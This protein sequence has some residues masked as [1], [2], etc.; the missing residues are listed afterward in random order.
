MYRDTAYDTSQN[1]GQIGPQLTAARRRGR[2]E[3]W[4]GRF[5]A[6][7][8]IL[9][10]CI[11]DIH[12]QPIEVKAETYGVDPMLAAFMQCALGLWFI[13]SPDQA[14]AQA[15]RGLARAENTKAADNLAARSAEICADNDVADFLPISR[16]LGGAALVER[17]DV[18]TGL[19]LMLQGLAEQRKASGPFLADVMLASIAAAHGRT[20][21]W[22]EALRCADEG[23][24]LSQTN[25]ERV[26]AAELWRIK[27]ELLYG[28]ARTAKRTKK[29]S[30]RVVDAADACFQRALETHGTRRRDRSS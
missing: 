1:R 18:G 24:E 16:F 22:D 4:N 23:I 7:F 27:G 13:G 28:K 19:P 9:L 6:A 12:D 5:G 26:Y 8:P 25:L 2:T 29:G 3:L 17:G 11:E 14:R 21:R 20:G 15:R 10:E 30:T